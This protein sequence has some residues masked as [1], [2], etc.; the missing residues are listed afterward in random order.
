[1]EAVHQFRADATNLQDDV[2]AALQKL[3]NGPLLCLIEDEEC[4]NC[5]KVLEELCKKNKEALF[6]DLA[7]ESE[8]SILNKRVPLVLDGDVNEKKQ[9]KSHPK[10]APQGTLEWRSAAAFLHAEQQRFL[11][12]IFGGTFIILN[13]F[14]FGPQVLLG[15]AQ[16]QR[17]HGDGLSFFISGLL[18]F[19]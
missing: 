9:K 12:E 15:L 5:C 19:N 11:R 17:T 10:K 4:G 18:Q 3:A 2:T 7:P 6:G 8:T 16:R 13:K 1:M 14:D